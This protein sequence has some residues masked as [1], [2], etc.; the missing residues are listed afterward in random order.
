MPE[1]NPG[2]QKTAI[3][4]VTNP[5]TGSFDYTA[6]LY[7]GTDLTNV[8]QASFH[9]DAGESKSISLLVT[10]PA[11]VGTYPVHLGIFSS[12]SLVKMYQADDIV[13][14]GSL[15]GVDISAFYMINIGELIPFNDNDTIIVD[16][17]RP[18]QRIGLTISNNSPNPI[19]ISSY[20]MVMSFNS[21]IN[22]LNQGLDPWSPYFDFIP[23]EFVLQPGARSISFQ[24]EASSPTYL[25]TITIEADEVIIQKSMTVHFQYVGEP[26]DYDD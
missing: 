20:K 16:R 13:I 25:A 19:L 23:Q 21:Y 22:T 1:F 14:V 6:V 8:A 12:G 3:V 5:T 24:W 11:G 2:V 17:A 10:M 26:I 18:I 15:P 9:L 4:P 7:M